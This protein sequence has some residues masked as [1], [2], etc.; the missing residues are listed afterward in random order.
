MSKILIATMPASGHVNPMLAIAR[1]LVERGAKIIEQDEETV[2]LADMADFEV[3]SFNQNM[4]EAEGFPL[5]AETFHQHLITNDAFVIASPEYNASMPGLLKNAI[6][7]VS[8]YHPQPFNARHGLLLSVSPS[9]ADG[10]WR[11]WALRQPLEHV[12]A[13]MFPDMF[14]LAQAHK[15][16]NSQSGIADSELGKRLELTIK[17]FM[18]LVEAAKHYPSVKRVPGRAA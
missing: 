9:M 12:G 14:S 10:N 17:A 13:R 1:K 2:D 7:W 16:F 11:L 8:R 6:D 5:G 4:H 15:S 3:P 18:D